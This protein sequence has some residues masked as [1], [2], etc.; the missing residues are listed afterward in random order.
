MTMKGKARHSA[1]APTWVAALVLGWLSPVAYLHAQTAAPAMTPSTAG[2]FGR[3]FN[4]LTRF[5][6]KAV[7][8]AYTGYCVYEVVRIEQRFRQ[9]RLTPEERAAAEYHRC[10]GYCF[11]MAGGWAGGL[12]GAAAGAWFGPTGLAVGAV[13]GALVGGLGGEQLGYRLASPLR[14]LLSR[15]RIAVHYMTMLTAT[16]LRCARS[17]L[18]DR[19]HLKTTRRLLRRVKEKVHEIPPPP[20]GS[21]FHLFRR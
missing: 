9:G 15:A 18:S 21:R 2:N 20:C 19:L 7:P 4:G 12:G 10:S 6:N 11:S 1:P 3:V 5:G 17:F 8:A 14:C 13:A 16:A